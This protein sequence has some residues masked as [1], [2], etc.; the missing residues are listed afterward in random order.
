MKSNDVNDDLSC[1]FLQRMAG[2]RSQ[3]CKKGKQAVPSVINFCN[4][5]ETFVKLE[6]SN[7]ILLS[8]PAVLQI[9]V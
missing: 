4:K 7:R 8:W 5:T 9:F 2:Y 1:H 3:N 6:W